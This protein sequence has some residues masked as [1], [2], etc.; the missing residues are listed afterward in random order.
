MS[1]VNIIS[2]IDEYHKQANNHPPPH[3]LQQRVKKWIRRLLR[4]I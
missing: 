2:A 3:L 4:E 1:P